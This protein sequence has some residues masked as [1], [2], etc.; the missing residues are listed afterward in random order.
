[1][2]LKEKKNILHLQN[3]LN[4][5]LVRVNLSVTNSIFSLP[6]S[7][8]LIPTAGIVQCAAKGSKTFS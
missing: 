7:L 5:E 6:I 4:R 8:P 1:M 2:L 3:L